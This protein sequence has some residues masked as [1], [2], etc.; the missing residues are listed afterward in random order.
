MSVTISI[1]K[2][3]YEGPTQATR[4]NLERMTSLCSSKAERCA[5]TLML[6]DKEQNHMSD[7]FSYSP[8]C[9]TRLAIRC[10]LCTSI[11]FKTLV[12]CLTSNQRKQMKNIEIPA[13][14]EAENKAWQKATLD[15]A[16]EW[17][18]RFPFII[19]KPSFSGLWNQI[20]QLASTLWNF[21]RHYHSLSTQL[22][23][24]RWVKLD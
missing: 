10:A 15:K 4:D 8:R 5:L 14:K 12:Q 7:L 9:V 24:S 13:I 21:S 3:W 17:L 22:C 6:F 16:G 23:P 20:S 11:S 19:T 2:H 1:R 18:I